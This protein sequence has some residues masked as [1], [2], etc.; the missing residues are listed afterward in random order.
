MVDIVKLYYNAR[1][2]HIKL[3]TMIDKFSLQSVLTS[4][5]RDTYGS[6]LLIFP[7]STIRFK[8]INIYNAII[9]TLV[10]HE[11]VTLSFGIW[12]VIKQSD[13]TVL[14]PTRYVQEKWGMWRI[15][16]PLLC[17]KGL[18]DYRKWKI[19][20]EYVLCPGQQ[21]NADKV[22]GRNF[23][24][25]TQFT[26]ASHKFEANNKIMCVGVDWTKPYRNI[27]QQ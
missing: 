12:Q 23:Q 10:V 26:K 19:L 8:L 15:C 14:W 20:E 3:Q 5:H 25:K 1:C 21:L 22:A 2:K 17:M 6:T 13:D 18:C 4:C 27:I 9:L 7:C 11:S 24:E 16:R